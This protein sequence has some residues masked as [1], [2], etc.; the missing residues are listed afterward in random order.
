[1]ATFCPHLCPVHIGAILKEYEMITLIYDG[2]PCRLALLCFG[3][4]EDIIF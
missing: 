2:K 3:V 1:M 4:P